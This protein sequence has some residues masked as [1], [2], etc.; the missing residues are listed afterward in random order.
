MPTTAE[1]AAMVSELERLTAQFEAAQPRSAAYWA[2]LEPLRDA[3]RR[4]TTMVTSGRGT[5]ST[6][7]WSAL[8]NA[9]AGEVL[10]R[11]MRHITE[12]QQTD[13]APAG[14]QP[15]PLAPSDKPP[16]GSLFNRAIGWLNPTDRP[17]YRRPWVWGASA[18]AVGTAAY[19]GHRY[20]KEWKETRDE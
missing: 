5:A 15:G 16:V 7:A 13:L 12:E 4:A 20:W 19:F 1:A 10:A 17:L 14:Q 2:A 11:H 18:V 3:V 9:P 6:A 8:V